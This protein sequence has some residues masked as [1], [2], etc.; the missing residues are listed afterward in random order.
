MSDT[1][2]D[3]KKRA[4][5]D[6]LAADWNRERKL[7]LAMLEVAA[8]EA[9][10]MHGQFAERTERNIAIDEA[11]LKDALSVVRHR[12]LIIEAIDKQ[13]AILDRIAV[14]LERSRP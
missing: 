14:A 1:F 6:D 5:E 12:A 4:A 13:T 7:R 10:V 3:E 8:A 11:R 9:D 2:E